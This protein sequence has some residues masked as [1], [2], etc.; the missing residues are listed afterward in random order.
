MR[1]TLNKILEK[2]MKL[3][4]HFHSFKDRLTSS[5][6]FFSVAWTEC[7]TFLILEAICSYVDWKMLHPQKI[8]I[9]R[10]TFSDPRLHKIDVT[11]STTSG[12]ETILEEIADY[13]S[14]TASIVKLIFTS[15]WQYPMYYLLGQENCSNC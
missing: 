12:S 4:N 2:T 7:S 6:T 15:I 9:T 5:S 14:K 8:E 3:H 11:S 10:W 13:F 1:F